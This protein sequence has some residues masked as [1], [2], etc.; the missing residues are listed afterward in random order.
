MVMMI[1]F[2]L[3]SQYGQNKLGWIYVIGGGVA[4]GAAIAALSGLGIGFHMLIA[5]ILAAAAGII[6]M[7]ASMAAGPA[8]QKAAEKE[9]NNVNKQTA[10]IIT[11][12][13]RKYIG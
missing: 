1:G 3:M 9:L 10:Y 5:K 8:M 2:K 13:S 11:S 7:F 12:S 4:A 6:G